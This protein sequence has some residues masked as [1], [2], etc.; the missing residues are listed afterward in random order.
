MNG[1]A[2]GFARAFVP[3]ACALLVGA[4]GMAAAQTYPAKPVR[5]VV[6][7][8]PGGPTDVFARQYATRMSA[9]LNQ[10][11]V[12]DNKSGAGGAIGA[13]EVKRADPDGY[14]LLFGSA[15]NLGLYN[16]MSTA[17]L[18]DAVK[19]FV[20][21]ASLGGAP[22]VF[23]VHPAMPQTL[24]SVVEMAKAKPGT[25]QYGSPGQGTYLHIAMERLKKEAGNI[26]I[27]HIPFRGSSQTLTSVLG[28]QVNMSV[29]TLGTVLASH[30][31]GGLRIVAVASPK[32]SPLAPE[33]PTVDEAIGTKGFEAVLWNVVAAPVGTPPAVVDTLAKATAKVL[34]DATLIEQLAKLGI[35]PT[36][37]SS[38]A[39]ATAYIRAEIEKWRPVVEATGIKIQ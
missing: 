27:Q 12:V 30:R 9:V 14:T 11:V 35:Q 26:D 21:V 39:A 10:S 34:G 5:I 8:P 13:V 24:K 38:P 37:E 32:R 4:A 17:P 25:L 15:S 29:E 3:A 36:A 20:H 31:S 18:Y 22:T 19:D 7:F 1:F 6:P 2:R 33:V 16:L 28:G 23:A